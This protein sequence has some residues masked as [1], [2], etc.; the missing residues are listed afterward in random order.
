MSYGSVT[1]LEDLPDAQ[2]LMEEQPDNRGLN[3]N[4][5]KK[6]IRGSHSLNPDS[7]MINEP[8]PP[9][10]QYREPIP[11]PPPMEHPREHFFNCIDIANH[12]QGC[13]I[14]SKFYKN[15]NIIFI[16][17]IVFLVIFCLLLLKKVLNV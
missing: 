5:Y 4:Q 8:Q 14:C 12:I 13:P 6:F 3:D 10:M 9:P 11:P 15:D 17:I 2:Q 1:M 7:G 16:A